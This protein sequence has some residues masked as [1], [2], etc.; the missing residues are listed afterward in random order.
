MKMPR[1]FARGIFDYLMFVWENDLHHSH[2]AT[3]HTAACCSG[4]L[5]WL[6]SYEAFS[7]DDQ[8]GN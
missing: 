8:C 5:V 4:I 6:V 3:W 2:S 1:A 7:G